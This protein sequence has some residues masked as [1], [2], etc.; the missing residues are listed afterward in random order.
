VQF[1]ALEVRRGRLVANYSLRHRRDRCAPP[2]SLGRRVSSS[3]GVR[4]G[5]T[6]GA[7]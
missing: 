7:L 2:D 4:G 1:Q 6:A 5:G 3:A